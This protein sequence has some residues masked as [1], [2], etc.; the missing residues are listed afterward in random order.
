VNT[1][2]VGLYWRVGRLILDRQDAQGWGAGVT[3][4]LASDLRAE[5]PGMRG[6]SPR[7]MAYMRAF[8]AA[9]HDAEVVQQPV[10]QLPWGHVTVLLDKL[11]DRAGREFY[12]ERAAAYG[13]SRAVLTNHITTGLRERS[14]EAVTNFPATLGPESDL[15]GE[16]LRDPYNLDFLELE[17]GFSERHLEDALVARLTHFLAELGEG[18]AFV[19]RQYRLTVDGQDFFADLLFFHLGLRCYIVFELKVG[20]AVPE[21]LGQLNFYV[22]VVDELMRRPEHDDGPTIGILLAATRNDVV[23][24]YALRG[25]DTPLAV[26]TYTTTAALPDDVRAAL[27]S[28]EDL[29]DVVRDA[30]RDQPRHPD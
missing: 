17:P 23:V 21:H 4:R 13:W 11:D 2:L 19:G 9:F 20:G 6:F 8:A 3:A 1:E 14:G 27:P 26:S 30:S 16:I 25:Y 18:F 12:A 22:N 10:A 7:N 15:V 28:V 5:F 24:E 29:T